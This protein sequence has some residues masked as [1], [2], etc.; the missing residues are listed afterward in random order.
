MNSL[1]NWI[2]KIKNYIF[3]EILIFYNIVNLSKN[4]NKT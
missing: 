3:L 2:Q 4:N 1:I